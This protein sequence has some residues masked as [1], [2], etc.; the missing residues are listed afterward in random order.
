MELSFYLKNEQPDSDGR[1]MIHG[2]VCW[3]SEKVRFSTGEKI[4]PAHWK[5]ERV[6]SG[7]QF[8]SHINKTLDTFRHEI[9][10]FFY[11]RQNV[12]HVPV[13][14]ADVQQTIGRI[15]TENLGKAKPKVAPLILPAAPAY[16]AL[17]DFYKVYVAAM[18]ADRSP[19]WQRS[20]GVVSRHLQAFR[21]GMDWADLKINTLN[22]FKV[23]LQ[24]EEDHSDNTIHTYVGLLGGMCEYADK[25][26]I[27]IPRDYAWVETRP[28]K[29]IR[30]TLETPDMAQLI[31]ATLIRPALATRAEPDYLEKVRWY[32]LMACHTGLRRVDQWQFL[33]PTI[34][35]IENTNCL[36]A[37]QQKTG[38]RVAIPL[39]DDA[40][41]LLRNP[42][43]KSKPP[44][45]E[46]YNTTLKN[47]GEQAE[48]KRPVTVG[49][50]YKGELVADNFPLWETMSSHMAR[51]TFATRLS[52]GGLNS[53]MLQHLLG[54]ESIS[55]TQK[56]TTVSNH[57]VVQQT[58][59]IWSKL[60]KV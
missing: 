1:V 32:F 13:E 19:E 52:E 56:Y 23:Y 38:N 36:M 47:I 8:A 4:Q 5:D 20:V 2:R 42:V 57:A 7:V 3:S 30:P 49:S 10:T 21:P 48:L 35:V 46:T 51:R 60:K 39:S 31:N 44:I 29:V 34:S 45:G 27:P 26:G 9:G 41:H 15:R 53:F 14:V 40:Y 6:K 28:G 37:L 43:T 54:H 25:M 11:T 16:P 24:E 59:E 18:Q 50:F 58:I 12:D 55:S 17:S 33:N 22:Q